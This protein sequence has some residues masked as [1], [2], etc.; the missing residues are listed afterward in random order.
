MGY[1]ERSNKPLP[2]IARLN[3]LIGK[4]VTLTFDNGSQLTG[5]LLGVDRSHLNVALNVDGQLVFVRGQRILVLNQ[6]TKAIA[7]EAKP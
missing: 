3:G 4:D 6:G 1:R 2:Y 7:L 5:K